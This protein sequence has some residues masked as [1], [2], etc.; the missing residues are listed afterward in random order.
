MKSALEKQFA[1]AMLEVLDESSAHSGH[2]G[3]R[4]EGE[5]HFRVRMV[6]DAFIGRSR[7]DRQ[8]M[9]NQVL[10]EEFAMGL[11]ALAL[12]LKTPDEFSR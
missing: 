11:H 12:D 1:P 6:S 7:L 5:T 3:A 4:P 9:V 10:H 8:R 2:A